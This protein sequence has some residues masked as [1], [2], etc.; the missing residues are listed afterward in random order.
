MHN[1]DGIAVGRYACGKRGGARRRP[2]SERRDLPLAHEPL[3]Q[4]KMRHRSMH[5][6]PGS[7]AR[8]QSKLA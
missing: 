4:E 1:F 5:I 2:S 8:Q 7:M 3:G 6:L